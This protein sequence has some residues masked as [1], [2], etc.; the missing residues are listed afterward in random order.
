MRWFSC[1]LALAL[2]LPSPSALAAQTVIELGK[3]NAVFAEPF[4]LLRGARELPDGRLLITDWIE[5]RVAVLDFAR[6]QVSDRGRVGGG[7]GEFRLPGALFPLPGDSTLLVDIGNARLD[8]L[9]A[10]GRI[11][12]T[13]LPPVPAAGAP[14]GTDD[15]GRIYFTIPAWLATPPLAG[16]SVELAVWDPKTQTTRV[17]ARIHGMT[18]P[19]SNYAP[20][21]RVPFVVFSRQDGWSVARDGEVVIVGGDDHSVSRLRAGNIVR[22]P[23]NTTKPIPAS[24]AE[25]TAY[26]RQFLQSS[27]TSGRGE[28]G[29]LGH[30]PSEW[31][32]DAQV[33][34][35][36]RASAF[37]ETL[38]FFRPGDIR[39]DALGRVWVGRWLSAADARRYEV[40]DAQG[41]LT[42]TVRLPKGRTLLA[43]GRQ[44]LYL[45]N[46]DED[47]LQWI[48]RY[49]LP[50]N[51]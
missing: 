14:G 45:V 19:A 15:A 50:G 26:V 48:E 7:P 2:V 28:G 47:G 23:A 11:V 17:L 5:Q 1:A 49:T 43:L 10:D 39:I 34:R 33:A 44:S 21:P 13:F 40:F 46:T 4:S 18:P 16:D 9:D 51:A 20:E 32:S 36:V 25:R 27:P 35:V 22:G 12:R 42:A 37:A 29:G 41:K 6:G 3:S 24:G 8:V 38:P 30:T 31:Q